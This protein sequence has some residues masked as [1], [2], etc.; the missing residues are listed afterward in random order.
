MIWLIFAQNVLNIEHNEHISR[1]LKEVDFFRRARLNN[2]FINYNKC[3]VCNAC[4]EKISS[5]TSDFEQKDASSIL[6]HVKWYSLCSWERHFTMISAKWRRA[7]KSRSKKKLDQQ[8][9]L[10]KT[11]LLFGQV[12]VYQ[13]I[14]KHFELL[15]SS[16]LVDNLIAIKLFVSKK[17]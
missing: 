6:R 3:Y 2:N 1:N 13:K 9:K 11:T 15:V 8:K 12:F 7:K 16:Q 4:C 5:N 17:I 10:F 14:R